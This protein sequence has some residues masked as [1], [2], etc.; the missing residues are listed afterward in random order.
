[1][2]FRGIQSVTYYTISAKLFALVGLDFS[3]FHGGKNI[4]EILNFPPKKKK[5]ARMI[6]AKNSKKL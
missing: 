5:I 6:R 2:G 4:Y 1:V 3:K